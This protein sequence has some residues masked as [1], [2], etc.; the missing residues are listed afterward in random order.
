MIRRSFPT[1]RPHRREPIDQVGRILF[2]IATAVLAVQVV[3][4]LLF[5]CL[6]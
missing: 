6:E 4:P 2:L 5:L 1:R 3:V